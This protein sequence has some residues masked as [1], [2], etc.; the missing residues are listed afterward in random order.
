MVVVQAMAEA[1]VEATVEAMV[2]KATLGLAQAQVIVFLSSN[3]RWS[4]W[5]FIIYNF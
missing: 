5:N 2:V 3:F 1:M 4:Y